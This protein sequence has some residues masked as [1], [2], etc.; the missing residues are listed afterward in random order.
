MTTEKGNFIHVALERATS[1]CF[2]THLYVRRT[3]Y[4]RLRAGF[5]IEFAWLREGSTPKDANELL[6]KRSSEQNRKLNVR[7][8]V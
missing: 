4:A 7:L 1:W 8:R 6:S 2:F 3:P 5:A